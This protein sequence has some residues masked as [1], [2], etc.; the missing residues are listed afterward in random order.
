MVF[1]YFEYKGSSAKSLACFPIVSHNEGCEKIG[2]TGPAV[3]RKLEFNRKVQVKVYK[4]RKIVD[5]L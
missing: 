2:T 3:L 5:F 4:I 1:I